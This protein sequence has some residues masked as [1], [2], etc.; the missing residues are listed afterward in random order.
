MM[1][2]TMRDLKI[3]GCLRVYKIGVI[4]SPCLTQKIPGKKMRIAR[5][6]PHKFCRLVFGKKINFTADIRVI[7]PGLCA[8]FDRPGGRVKVVFG[9]V[10]I[11]KVIIRGEIGRAH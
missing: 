4:V 8:S 9:S 10:K 2:E 7:R 11:K 1:P 5:P 3:E 6:Y